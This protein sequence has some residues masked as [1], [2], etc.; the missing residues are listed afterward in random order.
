MPSAVSRGA[1]TLLSHRHRNRFPAAALAAAFASLAATHLVRP[2][3]TTTT[4]KSLFGIMPP[5]AEAYDTASIATARKN[6][7]VYGSDD[8]LFGHIEKQQGSKPFGS[9]LDAGTGVHSLRWI[10]TLAE[11][12]DEHAKTQQ[13]TSPSTMT[14]FT[15]VTADET[16]RKN[17]QREVDSLGMSQLGQVVIGNWF[18]PNGDDTQS[19]KSIDLDEEG[20][21]KLYDT[22][23]A[24]YLIGA[25]DGFSPYAQDQMIDKLAKR[26]KPGGRLYIVGLQPL[27]DSEGPPD[28]PQNIICEVRKVRDACIL[29]AGDRCYREYPLDW[30][31]RQINAT[32][33]QTDK[34]TLELLHSKK[35]PILYR[36]NTIVKQIQVARNKLSRFPTKELTNEMR[37]V[38]S[39]LEKRSKEATAKMPDNRIPLGFDYV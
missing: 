20:N 7:L 14:D 1:S 35:F 5:V 27:P 39:D 25:M 9:F 15:A 33:T 2:A 36:H 19:L 38:L 26:L 13:K 3:S 34:T 17:V 23:L 31:E 30:I 28:S 6:R 11:E 21:L 32:L 37:A 4:S 8:A 16:M 24:D 29:L 12:D 10:A 18:P 22:I